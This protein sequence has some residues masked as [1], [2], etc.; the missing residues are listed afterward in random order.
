MTTTLSATKQAVKVPSWITATLMLVVILC[1]ATAAVVTLL[2]TPV[3]P[4]TLLAVLVLTGW[5]APV[6]YLLIKGYYRSKARR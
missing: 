4:V 6:A 3:V 1:W 2:T 5:S